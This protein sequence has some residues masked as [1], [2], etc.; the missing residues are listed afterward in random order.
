V[1]T[2]RSPA[3]SAGSLGSKRKGDGE[4]DPAGAQPTHRLRRVGLLELPA[5]LPEA[6]AADGPALVSITTHP[7]LL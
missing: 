2:S 5:A 4:V 1:V 3:S 7:D 6:L